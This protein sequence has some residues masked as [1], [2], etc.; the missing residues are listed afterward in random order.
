[1]IERLCGPRTMI[2]PHYCTALPSAIGCRL[3]LVALPLAQTAVCRLLSVAGAL[4]R[5]G[6]HLAPRHVAATVQMQP[7][8]AEYCRCYRPSTQEHAV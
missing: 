7:A 8:H 4:A 5:L 3:Q 2:E 1:M 6:I